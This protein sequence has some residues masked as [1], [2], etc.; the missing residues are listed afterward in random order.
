MKFTTAAVASVLLVSP[1]AAGLGFLPTLANGFVRIWGRDSARAAAATLAFIN[2]FG[3]AAGWLETAPY[4]PFRLLSALDSALESVDPGLH[5]LLASQLQL[6]PPDY[7]WPLLRSLLV[8]VL[9]PQAWSELLDHVWPRPPHFFMALVLAFVRSSRTE[10]EA[11]A[12]RTHESGEALVAEAKA[13]FRR[14]CETF[15]LRALLRD[16]EA[17][18]P[19]TVALGAAT[20]LPLQDEHGRYIDHIGAAMAD[21]ESRL[22]PTYAQRVWER[23]RDEEAV[24]VEALALERARK[25]LER[26]AAC[27]PHSEEE[28]C[29]QQLAKV[30]GDDRPQEEAG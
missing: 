4:A 9:P 5:A 14:E 23:C 15:E 8:E 28:H 1:T 25:A 27:G 13:V 10:L 22:D 21:A 16:A 29:R 30:S 18:A 6:G 12:Q 24:R 11:I 26:A 7:L 17:L 19:H 2:S 20:L 3:V